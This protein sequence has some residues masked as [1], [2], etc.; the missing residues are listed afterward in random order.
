MYFVYNKENQQRKSVRG[1]FFSK[2]LLCCLMLMALYFAYFALYGNRGYLAL[3]QLSKAYEAKQGQLTEL[4]ESELL[5]EKNI[6]LLDGDFLDL[7]FLEEKARV[8]LNY[9][10]KDEAIIDF[11]LEE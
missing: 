5:L 2:M 1:K 8:M 4:Q 7:D 6:A 3:S 10:K 9:S 11:H